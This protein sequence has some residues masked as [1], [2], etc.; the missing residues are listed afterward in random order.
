M[1]EANTENKNDA[2]LLAQCNDFLKSYV[3]PQA[4]KPKDILDSKYRIEL[5]LP[6]P[7]LNTK[8]AIAYSV[9]DITDGARRLYA[10]VCKPGTVQRFRILEKLKRYNNP[11]LLQLVAYGTV[12]LSHPDAERF[13]LVYD[14]PR[15][16]KLSDILANAGVLGE[17]FLARTLATPLA[18]LANDLAMMDITH[19]R[20]NP[21]NIYFQD[22][23]VLG[24]CA[25]EPCGYSQYYYYE[26]LERMQAHPAG[27]GNGT[28]TTDFYAIAVLLLEAMFGK[29]HFASMP[30]E[31]LINQIFQEGPYYT[32]TRN[33]DHSDRFDDLLRGVLSYDPEDRWTWKYIKPWIDGKRLHVLEPPTPRETPRAFEFSNKTARSK[34]ELAHIMFENW[35]N[36]P[37]AIQHNKIVQWTTV[38]LRNKPVSENL[39]R[40]IKTIHDLNAKDEVQFNE[41][42]M[43]MLLALDPAGPIRMSPIS[44]FLD[45]IDTL[46]A[47]YYFGKQEKEFNLLA[48][49]ID[50]NMASTWMNSQH[51]N[52]DKLIPQEIKNANQKLDRIRL[53]M[54]NTGLGFGIERI[55]YELTPE[56]PCLSP[57]LAGRYIDNLPALLT[58]LDSMA[59][60]L[61]RNTEPLDRHIFAYLAA[62]LNIQHNIKLHELEIIPALANS[63]DIVVLKLISTAQYRCG[64]LQLPGLTHWLA[65]RILPTMHCIRGRTL[66]Q[67]IKKKILDAAET[68]YTQN[69]AAAIIDSGYSTADTRGYANAHHIYHASVREIAALKRGDGYAIRSMRMALR[70]AKILAYIILFV[71]I[72]TVSE[73]TQP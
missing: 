57:M 13:V 6:L 19:G 71:T 68:G 22:I 15:G 47:E 62:K 48:R 2:H 16:Q 10:L 8:T 35:V 55:I 14:R 51:F 4:T 54:R 60:T 31:Y 46:C 56:L 12:N 26:S 28:N 33:K 53:S 11:N 52:E 17:Q 40:I 67:Q 37:E 34:R 43:R 45:G 66:R 36:I 64:T 63:N 58:H 9:A 30:K 29:Q 32:L 39:T 69:M 7:E 41:Q 25:S 44:M 5:S 72:Y 18:T 3:L 59:A 38:S 65:S 73:P 21:D 27:K 24:E 61:S 20:I 42:L 50:L 23:P 49:F 1:A 70:I